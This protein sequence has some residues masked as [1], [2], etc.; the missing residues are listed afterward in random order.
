MSQ[1]YTTPPVQAQAVTP[2]VAPQ[3]VSPTQQFAPVTT[4][5]AQ[6]QQQQQISIVQPTASTAT[7][8]QLAY[9]P[10]QAT[11]PATT[12]PQAGQSDGQG[13]ILVQMPTGLAWVP[14]AQLLQMYQQAATAPEQQGKIQLPN[15]QWVSKATAEAVFAKL[16]ARLTLKELLAQGKITPEQYEKAG[17]NQ[18]LQAVF[19]AGQKSKADKALAR[20]E[21][22]KQYAASTRESIMSSQNPY[23]SLGGT[24]SGGADV[25]SIG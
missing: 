8:N 3:V 7:Q 23:A 21:E 14:E 17:G 6:T 5:V 9:N 24:G 16:Q 4:P 22:M 1:P 20:R 12:P 13:N 2:A 10:Q 18:D 25:G 15:G 19:A 11:A